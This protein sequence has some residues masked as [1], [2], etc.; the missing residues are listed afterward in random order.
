[1]ELVLGRDLRPHEDLDVFVVFDHAE[2]AV[3]LLEQNGFAWHPGS[4]EDGDVFYRRGTLLLD[5]VPLDDSEDPPRAIGKL[6]ALAFP[7]GLLAPCLVPHESGPISTLTPAMHLAMKSSVSAFYGI[8][9]REKD[10]LDMEHLEA[11]QL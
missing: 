1:M 5:L 2:A 9:P 3:K 4:I 8:S 10:L 6:A 11:A 7:Q